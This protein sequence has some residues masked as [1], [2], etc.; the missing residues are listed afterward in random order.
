[1]TSKVFASA[2]LVAAAGTLAIAAAPAAGAA[3]TGTVCAATAATSTVCQ[4]D[5]NAQVSAIP[6]TV[7]Y[8]MQDP[9]IGPYVLLFHHTGGH[10]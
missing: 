3:P 6:P 1:M 7:D 2:M 9:F 8:G 4:S 5:G 10:R